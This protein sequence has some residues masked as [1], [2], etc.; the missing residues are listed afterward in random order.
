MKKIIE[1]DP[2]L[3]AEI[4]SGKYQV[5]TKSGKTVKILD[6]S[7]KSGDRDDDIVAK[8]TSASGSENTLLYYS[9]GRLISD[10]TTGPRNN[11]LVL[12]YEE[13][14][15]VHYWPEATKLEEFSN[16]RPFIESG[17]Y[18]AVTEF[19]EPAEVVKWDC[20]GKY[21]ILAVIYDGDTDDS[22]FYDKYG[23]SMSGSRL[24]VK[25]VADVHEK[26]YP[27]GFIQTVCEYLEGFVEDKYFPSDVL[28]A[29]EKV[30]RAAGKT[31]EPD[32]IQITDLKELE[33]TATSWL[34]S[35]ATSYSLDKA[36]ELSKSLCDIAR[37]LMFPG[38]QE[39]T[40]GVPL[41][42]VERQVKDLVL[43]AVKNGKLGNVEVKSITS[44]LQKL[45][46]PEKPKEEEVKW[47]LYDNKRRYKNYVVV[48]RRTIFGN[49]KR[50]IFTKTIKKGDL[51]SPQISKLIEDENNRI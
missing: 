48:L 39:D 11:D 16:N 8:V 31:I 47:Y 42:E 23:I 50:P 17:D 38:I 15:E 33:E 2:L 14:D 26:D 49:R 32:V 28:E 29:A 41:G 12:E 7:R 25:K 22:C 43:S 19:G 44:Q 35:S 37:R 34:Y 51:Y 6:W 40:Q 24:L 18:M 1:F 27:E 20:K 21:P 13:E 9:S 3:R 10:S 45:L 36:K 4:E 46:V 30:L 5:K